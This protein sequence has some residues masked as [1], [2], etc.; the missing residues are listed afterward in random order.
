VALRS[1]DHSRLEIRKLRLGYPAKDPKPPADTAGSRA[2][3]FFSL[4]TL[5]PLF[6]ILE[7]GAPVVDCFVEPKQ[8]S[9]SRS[10]EERVTFESCTI[11]P[12]AARKGRF[13]E[14]GPRF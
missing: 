4:S 13:C 12:G 6:S 9:R 5:I 2:P 14:D 1:F 8:G 7:V 11:E 10:N 3:C